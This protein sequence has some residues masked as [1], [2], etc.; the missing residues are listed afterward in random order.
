MNAD[1]TFDSKTKILSKKLPKVIFRNHKSFLK[2]TKALPEVLFITSYP[3]RECGIATYSQDL[4][5]ALRN[6]FSQSF[7]LKVC[8]LE[9]GKTKNIYPGEVKYIFDT[10][11]LSKYT[12][13]AYTINNDDNIKV[14]LL[15][16]EF[17]FFQQDAQKALL[18]FLYSL[19]KPAVVVFHT[20]LPNPNDIAKLNIRNIVAA[21]SSII[22]MTKNAAQ[23]LQTDYD[24]SDEKIRVIAHGTHLVPYLDKVLLKE[25]YDLQGKKI[26]STFGLLSSGKSIETTL[27]AM[28]KIISQNPD[29][30]FLVIGKTHP[31]VVKSEGEAYRDM[32]EAK[33]ATLG[34][35]NHVKFINHYLPLNDLL[36]FLQLTDIYLFTSKDPNQAVSGTFSYAMSCGCSIV[37]TPI[38]HAKELLK[39]NAGVFIDFQNSEQLANAVNQLMSD[40]VLRNELKSNSLQQILPTAWENSAVSHAFLFQEV[41]ADFNGINK[42]SVENMPLQYKIPIINL[43]HL[44]KMTTEVGMIQFAK[45]NQP[46][47][48]SGYTLDDNAR[49]LIATCMHYEKERGEDNLILIHTYL[50][51]IRFCQQP[52]GSFLNYVDFEEKFTSQNYETNLS[53]SNGRALWA[54][55]FLISKS[56]FLPKALI[57]EAKEVMDKALTNIVQIFSPRAMSFIIKGLYYRNLEEKS[58]INSAIIKILADRLAAMYKHEKDQNWH[59]F[60]SYLTYGNSILP[61]AMLFAWSDTGEE[62]YKEIAKESF[63]FLLSLTFSEGRIKVISNK[64]WLHKGHESFPIVVGGEQPIDVAYTILAMDSFYKVF[65]EES[66]FHK[67]STAFAWFLGN[68]HLQQIIYNPCTG[69][70]FDGLEEHSVNLNQGAESTV[71][72]LMARLTMGK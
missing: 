63:D 5:K 32:L 62:V 19:T 1:T 9:A 34:I 26:L 36:E 28:P 3:P 53:D 30:M 49:A 14:V 57:Q 15:Q 13:L 60:E 66:Y 25:K 72:Y 56:A 52:D 54:L 31:S 6:K 40:D 35:G 27:D 39:A 43:H 22:V 33:V 44:K 38:P 10:H 23:I 46:D 20:V 8:A 58:T 59:W 12:K 51:F 70:C 17:G 47:I 61:E 50:N 7:S 45:I 68:N 55:G 48:D 69:G 11:D 42:N 2:S 24:V 4:L 21:C 16:H 41:V 71:S 65:K 67:K 29:V 37:S 18:Q 64:G